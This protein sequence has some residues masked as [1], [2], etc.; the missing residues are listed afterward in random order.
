MK[1]GASHAMYAN[2]FFAV[3][4]DNM[5]RVSF[6]EAVQ[7]IEPEAPFISIVMTQANAEE[8]RDLLDKLLT[9]H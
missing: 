5:M 1:P 2:R 4:D 6:G 8:L 9:T 3:R 7:G